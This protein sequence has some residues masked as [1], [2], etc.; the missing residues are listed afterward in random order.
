MSDSLLIRRLAAVS[1]FITVGLGAMG[2]HGLQATISQLE[3][4]PEWW[5]KAVLYQGLH[6]AVLLALSAS[7]RPSRAAAW[8][9]FAGSAIFSGSLYAMA[10][11]APRWFGAVT[12]L[13]GLLLLAGWLLL[14]KRRDGE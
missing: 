7:A 9:F 6:A 13:G 1:G 11:G 14:L 2:A 3:K 10:L 8:C 12:P 5:A 4:G